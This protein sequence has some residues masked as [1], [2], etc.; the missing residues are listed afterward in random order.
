MG[1]QVGTRKERQKVRKEFQEELGN[2]ALVQL[3]LNEFGKNATER[4][5]KKID[6]LSLFFDSKYAN[7]PLTAEEKAEKRKKLVKKYERFAIDD[8]KARIQNLASRAPKNFRNKVRKIIFKDNCKL[9]L[10]EKLSIVGS[11]VGKQKLSE[12]EIY[13]AMLFM[14]D[15]GE[16]LT[17]KSIAGRLGC[18]TRTI[19]RNMST[20]LKKEKQLL[21]QEL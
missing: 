19:H 6:I 3:I 1:R 10:S 2:D 12:A 7:V 9:S 13:D 21:N 8:L 14:H 20:E 5:R 17:I 15:A 11:M 18:S 16:K 4:S